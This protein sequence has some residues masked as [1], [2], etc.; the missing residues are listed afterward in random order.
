MN[1]DG[2]DYQDY[3]FSFI[4]ASSSGI[5]KAFIKLRNR[6]NYPYL[7]A[8]NKYLK[9]IAFFDNFN[10]LGIDYMNEGFYNSPNLETVDLSNLNLGNNKCF[11]NYFANDEKL[12]EVKFQGQR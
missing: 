4:Y 5:H 7:F 8:N 3:P 12:K 1:F 10:S 2:V 9:Y 6:C 11:M